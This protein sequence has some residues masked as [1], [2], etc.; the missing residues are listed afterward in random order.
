MLGSDRTKLET[1]EDF[2]LA[3]QVA[4]DMN[5]DGL[6][7]V[8][9]YDTNSNA[10]YAAENFAANGIRTKVI[11]APSTVDGDLRNEHMEAS[12]GFDTVSKLYA[13]LISNLGIDATSAKKTYHFCRVMGRNASH[14]ALEVALETRPN[15]C[16]IGEEVLSR[17]K[18]LKDITKEIA[19]LICERA[20]AGKNYG[21]IVMPEGLV[22]FVPDLKDL[23]HELSWIIRSGISDEEEI[24][25]KLPA[26]QM[27]TY[28]A[29]PPTF[30]LQLLFD[31][32]PHGNCQVSRTEVERLLMET[33]KIEL[34]QRKAKGKYRGKFNPIGHYFGYEGRCALPTNFDCNYG[35]VLGHTAGK[36]R[37]RIAPIIV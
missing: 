4:T 11:S 3:R 35:Y 17:N 14:V 30:A 1:E 24:I 2:K 27:E 9:G 33:V 10:M 36:M 23:I 7:F 18:H 12:L 22:E 5:L 32:D 19:D 20:E 29:L 31:R 34:G 16:L 28:K 25:A 26:P 8:G 6:V 15:L 13:E 37:F 21:L